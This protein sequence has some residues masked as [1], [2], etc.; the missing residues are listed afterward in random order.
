MQKLNL[1]KLKP[2]SGAFNTISV[3]NRVGL[4]HNSQGLM[5]QYSCIT[6]AQS[7]EFSDSSLSGHELHSPPD[8][9]AIVFSTMLTKSSSVT[10]TVSRGGIIPFARNTSFHCVSALGSYTHN[11]SIDS[12]ELTISTHKSRIYT[13]EPMTFALTEWLMKGLMK[14]WVHSFQSNSTRSIGHFFAHSMPVS[15]DHHAIWRSLYHTSISR[16]LG[17]WRHCE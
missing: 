16:C 6:T 11:K 14:A 7:C 12:N 3:V 8:F 5:R 1:M 4:F 15:S 10:S 9:C 2:A 13:R 17:L